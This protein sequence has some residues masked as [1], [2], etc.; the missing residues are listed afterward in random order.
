MSTHEL[1]MCAPEAM[2]NGPQCLSF[3]EL[4]V[5]DYLKAYTATGRP[6]VPPPALPAKAA[7]RAALNLP[8]LFEPTSRVKEDD[9]EDLQLYEPTRNGEEVFH[10]ISANDKWK[11]WSFEELRLNA[12]VKGVKTLPPGYVNHTAPTGSTVP[13]PI[14]VGLGPILGLSTGGEQL[15]SISSQADKQDHSLEEHRV[16]YLFAQRELTSAEITAMQANNPMVAP[17]PPAAAPAPP[18]L[19]LFSSPGASSSTSPWT[20]RPAAFRPF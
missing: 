2:L 15:Q 5:A 6:P 20:P 18:S 17:R 10:S 1:W 9:D 14:K 13:P 7:A 19:G 3:E 8:P 16:A 4:R 11:Q 12:Y